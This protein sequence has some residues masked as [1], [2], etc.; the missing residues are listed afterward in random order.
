[1]SIVKKVRGR[2]APSCF[3]DK[4]CN[5]HNL[6]GPIREYT[7]L[8]APQTNQDIFFFFFPLKHVTWLNTAVSSQEQQQDLP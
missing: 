8:S 7:K 1:M 6:N 4:H 3:W 2:N 5:D